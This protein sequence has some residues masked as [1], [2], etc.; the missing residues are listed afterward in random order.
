MPLLD[1]AKLVVRD[2]A[3]ADVPA[4][5]ALLQQAFL[6]YEPQYTPAAFAATTPTADQIQKRWHEGPVWMALLA[7][8]LVGTVAAVPQAP[9]LYVRSMAVQPQ[10]RGKGIGKTLLSHIE[11][12]AR[13]HSFK[14]MYLSTTPFLTDAIRLYERFGFV[15]TNDGPSALCGTPIFTMEKML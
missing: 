7:E 1:Q 13:E 6:E 5:A 14:R 15:R 4:I 12:Y 9:A 2:A 8:Q 3:L 10:G 11:E